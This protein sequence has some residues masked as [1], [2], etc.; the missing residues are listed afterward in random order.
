METKVKDAF[1]PPVGDTRSSAQATQD[2][3]L[4]EGKPSAHI[5]GE[6]RR[7]LKTGGGG[8]RMDRLAQGLT[9]SG[10]DP[11]AFC[12]TVR[13][14]LRR[15]GSSLSPAILRTLPRTKGALS[16]SVLPSYSFPSPSP[17]ARHIQL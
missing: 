7:G 13:C 8:G 15:C 3:A 14:L 9:R 16:Q 11:G 6:Q 5:F 1:R 2:P 10:V 12:T 17:P 4:Q